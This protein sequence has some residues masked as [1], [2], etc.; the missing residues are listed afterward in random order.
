MGGNK[1]EGKRLEIG[2]R[3]AC[4]SYMVNTGG[5]IMPFYLL[6]CIS[7]PGRMIMMSH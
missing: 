5:V 7:S 4:G 2:K 3:L 1:L 6:L